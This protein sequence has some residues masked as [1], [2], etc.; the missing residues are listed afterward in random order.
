MP[1]YGNLYGA[2][3]VCKDSAEYAMQYGAAFVAHGLPS[4]VGALQSGGNKH[5]PPS[6]HNYLFHWPP[7][8]P[9]PI[10]VK[11]LDKVVE[12]IADDKV[13][14]ALRKQLYDQAWLKDHPPPYMVAITEASNTLR[15]QLIQMIDDQ[16]EVKKRVI[17][18]EVDAKI[19][20]AVDRL[21]TEFKDFFAQNVRDSLPTVARRLGQ[22]E[23]EVG[24]SPGGPGGINKALVDLTRRV[25]IIEQSAP[26]RQTKDTSAA[27][28][29]C[30]H[31]AE[32]KVVKADLNVLLQRLWEPKKGEI[33][34][35]RMWE[36]CNWAGPQMEKKFRE[37]DAKL[38]ALDGMTA[39]AEQPRDN[40]CRCDENVIN[41]LTA[42]VE[43][44][45]QRIVH[46]E[47]MFPQ[48]TAMWDFC[49]ALKNEGLPNFQNHMDTELQKLDK[50]ISAHEAKV[51]PESV[52][53][54]VDAAVKQAFKV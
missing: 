19:K 15:A 42:S 28:R 47:S 43:G 4:A 32:I 25:R 48:L 24:G 49:E 7:L 54:L 27:S 40:P 11:S 31:C 10:A 16:G 22:L 6:A 50:R 5:P 17:L 52:Q 45:D 38:E 53:S 51:N 2:T 35:Q 12:T 44:H 46:I 9:F 34:L 30:H 39:P 20:T 23:V 36:F 1:F 29:C 37:Y 13:K 33:N 14:V 41:T 3:E 26:N 18:I 21:K 8:T